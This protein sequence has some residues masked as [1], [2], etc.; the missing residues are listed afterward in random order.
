MT[1]S[2]RI[3]IAMVGLVLVTAGVLSVLDTLMAGV[4][5]VLGAILLG[6]LFARSLAQPLAPA[7]FA[8]PAMSW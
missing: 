2:T 8:A 5:A 3:T 4:V 1:L 6:A 7:G